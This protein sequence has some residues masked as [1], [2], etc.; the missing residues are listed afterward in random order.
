[1]ELCGANCGLFC[2]SARPG[3]DAAAP[4]SSK[5][6][7]KSDVMEFP[8]QMIVLEA[9]GACRRQPVNVPHARR[10]SPKL[11]AFVAFAR[12]PDLLARRALF[13]CQ[14]G[15]APWIFTLSR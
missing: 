13:T 6:R 7:V 10:R 2:A 14:P 5:R 12:P 11:A 4:A 9:R 1:M 15:L 8:S 3:T